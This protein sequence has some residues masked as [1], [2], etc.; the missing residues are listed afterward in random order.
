PSID[1]KKPEHETHEKLLRLA[2]GL[3]KDHPGLGAWKGYDE[4]AWVKMPAEPLVGAYHVFKELDPNHPV[5]IIQAPMRES[6]PLQTYQG[7]GDIFGVDIYPVT[8]P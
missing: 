5:I 7:A 1:P 3:Y 6:L 8:Y 4:P 2:I